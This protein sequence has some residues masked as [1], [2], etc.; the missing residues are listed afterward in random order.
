MRIGGF[1]K[2]TLLDFPGKMACIVFTRGCNFR[3]PFCHNAALVAPGAAGE[4]VAE[5]DVFS[6]L[7]KRR[8]IL[9]G[10]VVSGGE[11]LLQPGLED[12]LRAVRE[13]GYAVKLDTNG[14]FPEA[15]AA[16][17]ERGLMDYVAM[18]VKHVPDKYPAACGVPGARPAQL[19]GQSLAVLR[20]HAVPFELRTTLVRGV[21]TPEDVSALARFLGPGQSWFL[22]TYEDS[23][24]VLDG[25]GLS[26]FS[27]P[28]MEGMLRAARKYCPEAALRG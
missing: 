21:H 17:L 23:G 15:L 3:C 20:A 7:Q 4:A 26:A 18:D 8:G 16:L 28:E 10:V 24:G 14:S 11:P 13:L 5:Q 27:R 25:A 22:Q 19:V 1:Q 9:E 2:L 12:F 6:Y